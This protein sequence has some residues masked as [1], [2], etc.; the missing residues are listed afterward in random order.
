MGGQVGEE[1]AVIVYNPQKRA[2]FRDVCRSGSF[3][4]CSSVG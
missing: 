2:K 1:L 4:Y 3:S